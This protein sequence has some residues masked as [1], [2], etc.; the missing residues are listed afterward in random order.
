M[1]GRRRLRRPGPARPDRGSGRVNEAL[2]QSP[3]L[4]NADPYGEGWL[5]EIEV[6]SSA[7]YDGLLDAAGYEA[8]TG[9]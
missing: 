2:R 5:C 9:H 3:E 8:L 7:E 1:G 6:A 4:V